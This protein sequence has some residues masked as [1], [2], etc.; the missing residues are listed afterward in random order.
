[1]MVFWYFCFESIQF[2]LN[3]LSLFNLVH[4]VSDIREQAE[5]LSDPI[6]QRINK[7]N[8]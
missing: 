2:S 3:Q 5:K 8:N 4:F 6:T 1:M 7:W